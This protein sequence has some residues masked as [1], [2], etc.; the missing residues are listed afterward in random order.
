MSESLPAECDVAVIG[1]GMGGLTAAALAAKAGLRVC[2]LEMD[3]RPGGYLAGFQRKDFTFDTAI[4][5]LNGFGPA[6]FC[7]KVFDLIGPGSPQALPLNRIRRMKGD[8]FDYLLTANPDTLRDT[9]I[10]E[11]PEDAD[12]I[13][14]MFDA[15]RPIGRSF[16]AFADHFRTTDTMTGWEKAK[17]GLAMAKV[18]LP[19]IRYLSWSAEKGLDKFVTNPKLKRVFAAEETFLNILVPIAWA[20]ARDFQRPPKGGSQ[21]FPRWLCEVLAGWDASVFYRSRVREILVEKGAV[22]G[23]RVECGRHNVETRT[24]RCKYVIAAIDIETLYE[25]MLPQELVPDA[26]KSRQRNAELYPSSVTV[27]LAL[28]TRPEDL[29]LDEEMVYLSRDDV[30][31]DEHASSDPDKAVISVLAPSLRDPSLAPHGKG[32]LTIYAAASMDYGDFWKTGPDLERGP[33]YKA[34]KQTHADVLIDRVAAA[35]CPSLRDHILMCDVATPITHHRYTGN[36]NGSMMGQRPGK[37]NIKAKVASYR[38]PIENLYIGGHWAEYGGGVPMAL[39]AG[40]NSALLVVQRERPQAFR[41][42]ADV[43]DGKLAATEVDSAHLRRVSAPPP[44]VAVAGV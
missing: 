9:F 36:R 4:H 21:A 12:G 19:F 33:A 26:L 20:Y 6:G 10:R 35:L 2:V 27:H 37:L 8:S 41:M 24:L 16:D 1:A 28:N 30:P 13:R 11:F 14:R 29:G 3:A 5:W 17:H 39:K 38:T 44:A 22:A 23:V 31:R 25:K 15:A 43:L 34:F 42:L 7:T 32:T 18:G 40:V